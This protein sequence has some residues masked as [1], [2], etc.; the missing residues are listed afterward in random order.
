MKNAKS[1]IIKG[2]FH[3]CCEEDETSDGAFVAGILNN[4]GNAGPKSQMIFFFF[5]PPTEER[6]VLNWLIKTGASVNEP[7]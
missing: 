2:T 7:N 1:C 6:L 4:H 5:F 3:F